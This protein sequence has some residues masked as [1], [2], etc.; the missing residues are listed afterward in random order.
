MED[1]FI[2]IKNGG[3]LGEILFYKNVFV[4]NA[5]FSIKEILTIACYSQNLNTKF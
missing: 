1:I 5:K 4:S 2:L 3:G